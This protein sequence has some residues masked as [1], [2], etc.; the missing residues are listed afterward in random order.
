M[1]SKKWTKAD[2]PDLTRKI[3]IVTGGNSGLGFESV[4]TFAENGAEVI[5]ACRS[6]EKGEIARRRIGMVKGKIIVMQL[7]LQDFFS[8]ECFVNKFK[9]KYNCLHILLNNA[10]II[11]TPYFVTKDGLEGQMGIN[12]FGHFKLTGLLLNILNKTPKSRVVNVSSMSYKY[13]Q[14]DFG[15]LMF[16]KGNYSP[17]KSY[18]RSKLANLLFTYRLQNFFEQHKIDSISVAAHPGAAVT[19]LGRNFQSKFLYKLI[20]PLAMI[21]IQSQARGALPQIR[22]AVDPNVK[23]GEFYGPHRTIYG[24]PVLTE[25]NEASHNME[26]AQKLWEISEKITGI[27]YSDILYN[28]NK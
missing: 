1:R 8:I 26:D 2:I 25:S 21:I 22:A 9:Q 14:M 10:G 12:H 13:G 11:Y 16:G 15:N 6:L 23:G 19:N 18:V 24:Y 17:W 27:I 20:M 7:D 28:I 3:I 4:K 5:L